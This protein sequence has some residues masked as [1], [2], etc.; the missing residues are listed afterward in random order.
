MNSG[1]GVGMGVLAGGA[2]V[3]GAQEENMKSKKQKTKN[4]PT[5]KPSNLKPYFFMD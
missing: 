2:A 5:F 4:L 1:V 3:G